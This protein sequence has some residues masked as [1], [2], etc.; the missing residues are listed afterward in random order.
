MG[1]ILTTNIKENLDYVNDRIQ[2]TLKRAGRSDTVELIAVTKTIDIERILE[3]ID[4]GV[5]DIG[6]NKVQELTEKISAMGDITN[7]H[8]IGHLQTNKV[9]YIINDVHLIHSLDRLSLAKEI[10][11]RGGAVNRI[12][13]CLVQVNISGE[14]SKYG[15]DK[16]EALEFIEKVMNFKN[17]RIKGLMT[18][19]PFTDDESVI[20][21]SFRGLSKLRDEIISKNYAELDMKYLSMGMTNDFEIAIEEGANMVRVGTGIFGKRVY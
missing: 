5:T 14:E 9:K 10:N 2:Q 19:A 4:A 7:Y 18:I 6:E 21:E 1:E 12:I 13:D 8:M 15:I 17:I 11:K 16:S 20:R 3:A